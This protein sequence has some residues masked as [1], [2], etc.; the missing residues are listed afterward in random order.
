MGSFNAVY[1]N[2][3]IVHFQE[4]VYSQLTPLANV[5]G[6]VEM[7][8]N[9]QFLNAL[10]HQLYS[11]IHFLKNFTKESSA[12]IHFSLVPFSIDF[13]NF[14][15]YRYVL[16]S[17]LQDKYGSSSKVN[18]NYWVVMLLPSEIWMSLKIWNQ[19]SYSELICGTNYWLQSG[20]GNPS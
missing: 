14:R 2:W 12:L 7:I 18:L 15:I 9:N 3:K 8:W 1:I 17:L 20:L 13:S 19:F 5:A 6:M 4:K 11:V 16:I 10:V